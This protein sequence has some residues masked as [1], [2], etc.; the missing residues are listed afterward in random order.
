[1]NGATSK[2]PFLLAPTYCKISHMDELANPKHADNMAR[3]YLK[4]L[5]QQRGVVGEKGQKSGLQAWRELEERL[6]LGPVPNEPKEVKLP[7]PSRTSTIKKP[8]KTSQFGSGQSR[9]CGEDKGYRTLVACDGSERM[10]SFIA[11]PRFTLYL[12]CRL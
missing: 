9:S 4:Q 12:F 8:K 3:A 1:V 10:M 6:M 2:V 7:T 11:Q 5:R